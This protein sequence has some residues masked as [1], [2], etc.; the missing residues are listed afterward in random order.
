[1]SADLNRAALLRERGR[2]E[3]AVAFLLTHLAHEPEDAFAFIELA[4]NRS[5]IP[6]QRKQALE[7]ARTAT[8][9][10]PGMAFPLSLQARILCDLDRE[11]E[12]LPLAES[13]LALDPEDVHAWNS[14]CIA[15]CGLSR[16][17]EA[18]QAA[19]TALGI[20]ADDETASNLLAHTLRLQNKLSESEQESRRRLARNPENAFSFANTGWAALQRGDIAAAEAAFRESLR[21]DPEMEHAREGL[22]AS[23]RARSAFFRLFLKWSFFLQ[24][25]SEKN[26]TL[27]IIALF[28]GFKLLRNLAATVHPLLVVLVVA[29]YFILVF[30][31]WLS[32]G[33]ANFFLLKDPVARLSLDGAEKAEGVAIGFLFLGGLLM[34][35][36]GFAASVLPVALL[37]GAFMAT[38]IPCSLVFT[39]PS[40]K[41]RLLFGAVSLLAIA[42]GI[43]MAADTAAHPQ[44]T[45][46]FIDTTGLALTGI[47]LICA[48]ST[49]LGMIPS[50]RSV[51]PE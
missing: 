12:A 44:R 35:G 14:K 50:L 8:G 18:E 20:D 2:H 22:K 39:N 29:V 48:A 49:W 40:L 45:E 26:R 38:A 4:L 36:G 7:D 6:G 21:I 30:G 43:V 5:E 34:L 28:L 42:L 27:L 17:P 47:V 41:G 15:L 10:L 46:I 31:S 51:K 24:K 1:M 37:G 25:F 3:E 32:N 11:K 9:L 23:Y 16:W 33:L 19:R 13:A